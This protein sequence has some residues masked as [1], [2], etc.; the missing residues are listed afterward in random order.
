MWPCRPRRRRRPGV[1]AAPRAAAPRR[2]PACA[3]GGRRAAQAIQWLERRLTGRGST[4]AMVTHDRAFME[5]TCTGVLELDRDGAHLHGF[6]GPGSYTRFRQARA[7][8]PLHALLRA[9][10]RVCC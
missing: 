4:L 10:A 2:C 8:E 7:A 9:H 3:K 5:A 6:G 1:A